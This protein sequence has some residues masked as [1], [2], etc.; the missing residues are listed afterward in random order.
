MN[1]DNAKEWDSASALSDPLTDLLKSGARALIQQAVEA[2]LHAF[3]G[4]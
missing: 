1:K 3:L 4:D 2:E